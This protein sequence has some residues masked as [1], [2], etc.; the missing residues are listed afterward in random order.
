[1]CVM[2]VNDVQQYSIDA[3]QLIGIVVDGDTPMEKN[4]AK[5]KKM[6][7]FA[8]TIVVAVDNIEHWTLVILSPKAL[9]GRSIMHNGN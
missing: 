1:M 4:E 7:T 2:G 9:Q 5:N 8:A 6:H 3:W